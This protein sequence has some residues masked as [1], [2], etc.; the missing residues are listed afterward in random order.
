MVQ[1]SFNVRENCIAD[2]AIN[3]DF[4]GSSEISGLCAALNGVS[5]EPEIL[6][7]TVNKL[8][9][10]SFINGASAEDIISLF[11]L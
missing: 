2:L 6:A 3:G 9:V 4:F 5:I 11:S 10:G 7:H 8:P 1:V